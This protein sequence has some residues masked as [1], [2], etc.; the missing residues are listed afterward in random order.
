M[1]TALLL[2][3][4]GCYVGKLAGIVVPGTVLDDPR[5]RRVAAALPLVLLAA[6]AATQ[7]F[8]TDRHLVLDARAAAIVVAAVAVVMR[9]P[10]LLVVTAATA[11]TALVRLAG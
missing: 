1:W 10:F 2:G 4:A 8:A 6:L 9:A 5:V 7:T 3:A 11:T